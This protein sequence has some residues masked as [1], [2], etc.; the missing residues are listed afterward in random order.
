MKRSTVVL[1]L[2]GEGRT[3]LQPVLGRPLGAYALEA[4]ARLE[5]DAVLVLAAAVPAG[6]GD[7]EGLIKTVETKSPVFLLADGKRTGGRAQGVP[8]AL[9]TARALLEK[10]PD[11]DVLAVP[12]DRPL[13]RD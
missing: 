6:R 12:A 13:L 5:P 2:G 9:V 8:A 10:Y 11:C 1:L 7:W 3:V 4:A